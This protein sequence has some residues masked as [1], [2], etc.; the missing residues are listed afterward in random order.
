MVKRMGMVLAGILLLVC[1]L[2]IQGAKA[3]IASGNLNNGRIHWVVDD[4]YKL[5][6]TGDGAIPGMN[7]N[8]TNDW[9]SYR[10]SIVSVEI[11]EG[12]TEI[13][14]FDFYNFSMLESVTLPEGLTIIQNSAFS[15]CRKLSGIDLPDTLTTIGNAAFNATGLQ[16]IE[17]P[18]GV[19]RIENNAFSSC[20]KLQSVTLP[21]SLTSIG[22]SAFQSDKL[23]EAVTIPESV[24][25]IGNLAFDSCK[26]ITEIT[27]PAGVTSLGSQT[28]GNCSALKTVTLPVELTV[29]GQDNFKNCSAITDIYYTGSTRNWNRIVFSSGNECLTGAAIHCARDV[30]AGEWDDLFW[31]LDEDGL[32][33]VTGS[34]EMASLQ[35]GSHDNAWIAYR[36]QIRSAEIGSGITTVGAYAFNGCSQLESITLPNTVT[37]IGYHAFQDCSGMGTIAIPVSVTAIG[38]SA[39]SNCSKLTEIAIPSGVTGLEQASFSGCSALKTVTLP[40]AL[41]T[42]DGDCFMNCTAL[43]DVYYAGT[44]DQWGSITFGA[45]NT[46]L[47]GA[48]IHCNGEASENI[49]SGFFG[50]NIQWFLNTASGKLVV[51]GNGETASMSSSATAWRVYD[52]QIK[53]VEIGSGITGIGAYNFSSCIQMESITLSGN[54][55]QIGERCFG[56]CRKLQSIVVPEAVTEIK[57]STFSGC[58]VLESVMLPESLETIGNYA[59]QNCPKLETIVIP[60][61][62]TSVGTGAFDQNDQ[63][64][65][66][67]RIAG[68]NTSAAH[69][70][71]RAGYDF[72]VP[73]EKYYLFYKYYN[74]TLL[75]KYFKK[76][77]QDSVSI[78]IPDEITNIDSN[79]FYG[80][81]DL[82]S[83]TIPDHVSSIGNYVFYGCKSLKSI[84]LPDTLLSIE[85]YLFYQCAALEEITI[86][87][88]VSY[89][90][91]TAFAECSNLKKVTISR[92]C[93]FTNIPAGAFEYCTSLTLFEVP[94]QVT[95]IEQWAFNGCTDLKEI[96]IPANVTTI[97]QEAFLNCSSLTDIYF[98]G[99]ESQWNQIS[100]GSGNTVLATATKHFGWTGEDQP[101]LAGFYDFMGEN[102]ELDDNGA[103][104]FVAGDLLLNL[105]RDDTVYSTNK[106]FHCRI[107]NMEE[108]QDT[109]TGEPVF[110]VEQTGGT[111]EVSFSTAIREDHSGVDVT[112]NAMPEAGNAVF[113]VSCTVNGQVYSTNAA[114]TF[115][116]L[117]TRPS[118]VV[119]TAANPTVIVIGMSIGNAPEISFADGWSAGNVYRAVYGDDAD[120][121]NA[122]DW[123]YNGRAK[124]TGTYDVRMVAMS[125][126][127]CMQ[128]TIRYIVTRDHLIIPEADYRT[129]GTVSTL[130][131]DT[132][133]I[134]DEAFT[135]T[136][137]TEISI[138]AGVR[139]IADNAFD[140]T[141]LIAIYTN[142]NQVAQYYAMRHRFVIV[143]P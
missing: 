7:Y 29:I 87:G 124:G 97:G 107:E 34:G 65:I 116:R 22:I 35:S 128:K 53:D 3:E 10:G 49:V 66:R 9:L 102:Y 15:A 88:S 19:M 103:V 31:V 70:L 56:D 79:A 106:L 77:D 113:E 95:S 120:V 12:I 118:G 114:I 20:S 131:E 24:T 134:G 67:K 105:N 57:S 139:S 71:G 48:A 142:G 60:D 125:N 27:I 136:Q 104:F 55:T 111:T 43:A 123:A 64:M 127:I 129:F 63:Y 96:T 5:T 121:M 39:F 82:I 4:D 8:G 18:Y 52:G 101:V 2:M 51:T 46:V 89:F 140:G 74:G 45:N 112:L 13:G 21:S 117:A 100:V 119:V 86:P 36:D 50:D 122:F 80:C 33:T 58:S 130:P 132:T 69:A 25:T 91:H 83:V 28:F 54:L 30:A 23:L 42:V 90:C 37:L 135:G 32:L 62:V 6:I 75:N 38:S 94:E 47:T 44:A 11:G 137:I 72:R 109:L 41:T 98:A 92:N 108:I 85:P 78:V 115:E 26:A 143:I 1:V 16:S 110:R 141:G 99:T 126:N 14:N 40:A 138:P 73:G 17:I 59:F 93:T 81:K 68:I 84:R 133:E 76:A 61:G